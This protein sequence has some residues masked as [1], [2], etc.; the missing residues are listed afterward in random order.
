MVCM[1]WLNFDWSSFVCCL[2]VFATVTMMWL[3][4]A[5]AVIMACAIESPTFDNVT[6]VCCD[7]N[8]VYS[9]GWDLLV[10]L[11]VKASAPRVEDLGF[12]SCLC[13]D[14]SGL[15]HTSDSRIGTPVATMPGAWR[16]RVSAGTGW[17]SI[18]ILWLGEVES[19]ICSFY[20]SVAAHT[21]VWVNPS[22]R[23]TSM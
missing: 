11:A 2:P 18:Y 15:R 12:K 17:P 5:F 3:K 9:Y 21:V 23:Y 13:W 20:L 8:F 7:W 10:G 6:F 4:L 14:F 1:R 19:L 16:Y 22:L